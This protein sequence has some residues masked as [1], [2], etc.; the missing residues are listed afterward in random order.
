MHRGIT[1]S[2]Q[3]SA[4]LFPF[5]VIVDRG[6]VVQKATEAIVK[7]L[8]EIVGKGINE[9]FA[10]ENAA[11]DDIGKEHFRSVG[12]GVFFVR[13]RA[14]DALVFECEVLQLEHQD[15]YFI[16]ITPS[17]AK[18]RF[19][20]RQS[21]DA[22]ETSHST[23]A[24]GILDEKFSLF[25]RYNVSFIAEESING[26]LLTNDQGSIVWVNKAFE[27]TTGYS[28]NEVLGK[29]PRQ[30]LYGE[31]SVYVPADYVDTQVTKGRPFYFQNIGYTKS[32]KKFWFRALVQPISDPAGNIVGRFSTLEDISEIKANE[33]AFEENQKLWNLILGNSGHGLWKYD[34][35]KD[36]LNTS[37]QFK[38]LLGYNANERISKFALFRAVHPEC[39]DILRGAL[40]SLSKD[41]HNFT[42]EVR[43][44]CRGDGYRYFL[45]KCFVKVWDAN[46]QPESLVGTIS[47]VSEL[48]L[49]D[50]EVK[51]AAERLS[52]V[53]KDLNEAVLLENE[54]RR[55]VLVNQEFC[56]IFSVPVPPA[57]MIGW[58]CSTAAE[59]S[60]G[61]FKD[62]EG[63][64]V[65]INELLLRRQT[66]FDE[67]E[68][69]DGRILR[70]DFIPIISDGIYR[71][72]LWKYYDIT[73]QRQF[74]NRLIAQKNY[75][76]TILNEIPVDIVILDT[77]H[78]FTFINKSAIKDS[79]SRD[80]LIGKTNH[81][82]CQ[83]RNISAKLEQEREK[84]FQDALVYKRPV[85]TIDTFKQKDGAVV[86]MLRIL[87]PQIDPS[88]AVSHVIVYGIDITEQ[89]QARELLSRQKDYYNTILNE[90]PADIVVFTT[91]H[92][93]QFINRTAIRT[94]EL[95][96]WLIGKDDYDYC[97]YKGLSTE[98]ADKRRA[99]FHKA[100][101]TK[102][103]VRFID[104]HLRSDGSSEFVLRIMYPFL[105]KNGDV[106]LVIGY[107]IDVTEQI[108]SQRHAEIQERRINN[109][110]QIITDG[111]FRCDNNGDVN[112]YNRSFLRIMDISDSH[113]ADTAKINFF[114]LLP[115]GELVRIKEEIEVLQSGGVPQAGSFYLLRPN[116]DKV[117][118]RYVF[119]LAMRNEDAAFVVS[120]TDITDQVRKEESLNNIIEQEKELNSSKSRFIR[121]TSHEL[122]TPLAI[123]LA[124]AELLGMML[125]ADGGAAP[126]KDDLL[127]MVG[128]ISKE[129]VL[130]T[131]ILNQLMTISKIESGN[132]EFKAESIDCVQ[133]LF[134]LR[135]DLYSP[136]TD[137]RI[138]E[139]RASS[140]NVPFWGDKKL[141]RHAIVNLVNNAFKYSSGKRSPLLE[142]TDLAN[143]VEIK[144]VD[145]GI[146]I[147]QQDKTKL[148]TA[149][150]RASNV[151]VIQGTGL[152]LMVAEYAVDKHKGQMSFESIE[153][154]GTT[155][156]I[157][158]PKIDNYE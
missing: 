103:P 64:V 76:H 89:V 155:F 147:P 10:L 48:K 112:L 56:K 32:K 151:G 13:S 41:A 148:F 42:I 26:I 2:E 12:G 20:A 144:V 62:S 43:M 78:R 133:F 153:G 110:M 109:L 104:E 73:A 149:F 61:L 94:D 29:R 145:F 143:C 123:I 37:G 11:A 106:E 114:K 154:E 88:G 96:A 97:G 55:I 105:N 35:A 4:K 127:K 116:G 157:K 44:K 84:R 53:I 21:E 70:R 63:F 71:G 5:H 75:Y 59:Q 52:T 115:A 98:V 108:S 136:Y 19:H 14:N 45:I 24:K 135:S 57:E 122:R 100:V 156:T 121:I 124:N 85:Q 69:I 120:L 87:Y 119:T 91:D 128:R 132:I 118:V 60:K 28:M 99:V 152:G 22:A 137:G 101:E 79:A 158:L 18:T 27:R 51:A 83:Y 3:Q 31:D 86:H 67:L 82:Y 102:A 141:L 134:D 90:I 39:I 150:F 146:G 139:I 30:V 74:E 33:E 93:Y 47:D 65:R 68:M 113:H 38:N 95:R 111:V 142:I 36:T 16:H 66:A 129:V 126:G 140:E 8:G 49:R 50:L 1:F 117:Y 17:V 81:E 107:G 25:A 46:G 7:T 130:M 15:A 131:E 125:E 54:D 9:I 40:G 58:D 34:K 23:D 138:L 6:L 72:H 77:Q 80:W 92:K